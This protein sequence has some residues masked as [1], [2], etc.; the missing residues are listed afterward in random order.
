MSDW[1]D[2][3]SGCTDSNPNNSG[4]PKYSGYLANTTGL[5]KCFKPKQGENPD[6][7]VLD[8]CFNPKDGESAVCQEFNCKVGD[9]NCFCFYKC[10]DGKY[11]YEECSG[12][13]LDSDD[14]FCPTKCVPKP[15][16]IPT[17]ERNTNSYDSNKSRYNR[18]I[19]VL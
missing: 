7:S 6:C 18:N 15:L 4:P 10:G 5:Y 8:K 13:V 11:K 1:Y 12:W 3:Y 17:V 14:T 2:K 9:P 16:L 19:G